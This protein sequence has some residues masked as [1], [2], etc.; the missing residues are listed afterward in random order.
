MYNKIAFI[1][2]FVYRDF[3][4]LEIAGRGGTCLG[5]GAGGWDQ[6]YS[7]LMPV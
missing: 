1:C 4:K 5:S 6:E 2:P 3:L 7:N